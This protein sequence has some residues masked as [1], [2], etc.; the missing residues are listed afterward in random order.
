MRVLVCGGRDYADADCVNRT[1]D[2]LLNPRNLP[3]AS[4]GITI[5]HGGARGADA[6]ADKWAVTNYVAVQEFLADW[7]THGRRAG[8]IRNARML[9][10]GK[11]DLVVAFPGGAGTADMVKQARAAGVEVIEVEKRTH[12]GDTIRLYR[13]ARGLSLQ[14]VATRAHLS[15]PH[16]WG[17]ERGHERNPTV[18][19]LAT[20]A[21]ALGV[22]PEML[23]AEW[24]KDHGERGK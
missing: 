13:K 11:P 2:R 9:T 4:L 5:I 21:E 20:L 12:L 22:V 19:T 23:F 8:P 14:D 24:L 17:L 7:Q 3:L 15:K 10:E 16:V 1:L 6:L 18:A